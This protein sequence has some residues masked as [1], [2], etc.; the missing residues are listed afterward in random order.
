MDLSSHQKGILRKGYLRPPKK[1]KT[2]TL[3][4]IHTHIYTHTSSSLKKGKTES[5][6]KPDVKPQAQ[7]L[8]NDVYSVYHN[9]VRRAGEVD[10]LSLSPSFF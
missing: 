8:I 3:T 5:S 10:A 6:A 2:Y 1:K 9:S 7:S 4:V